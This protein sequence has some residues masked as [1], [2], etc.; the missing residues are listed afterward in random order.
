MS[1]RPI[2]IIAFSMIFANPITDCP[3]P[4]I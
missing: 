3:L 2:P 1:D 4:M